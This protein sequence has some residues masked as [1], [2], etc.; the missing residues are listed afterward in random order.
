MLV[1]KWLFHFRLWDSQIW[2]LKVSKRTIVNSLADRSLLTFHL[3]SLCKNRNGNQTHSNWLW[4]LGGGL[5]LGIG[6]ASS[7]L[8]F[9]SMTLLSVP[10]LFFL[11]ETW[12]KGLSKFETTDHVWQY[13]D[14]NSL[15]SLLVSLWQQYHSDRWEEYPSYYS[16]YE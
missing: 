13:L 7:L 5:I 2:T 14:Q 15:L 16:S 1:Q 6:W 3:N 9:I 4:A 12:L 11:M 10:W 8:G